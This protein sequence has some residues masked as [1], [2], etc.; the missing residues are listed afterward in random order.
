M[1]RKDRVAAASQISCGKLFTALSLFVI[2]P[3]IF[4]IHR[5]LILWIPHGPYSRNAA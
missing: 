2:Q 5:K 3:L 4:S 1:S